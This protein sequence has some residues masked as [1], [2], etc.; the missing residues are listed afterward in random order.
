MQIDI[1]QRYVGRARISTLLLPELRVF[2]VSWRRRRTFKA[3]VIIH[4][5]LERAGAPWLCQ[6]DSVIA[7]NKVVARYVD[8]KQPIEPVDSV[9]GD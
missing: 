5:P 6:E 4:N 1:L 9:P 3:D 8:V 2:F 7:Y